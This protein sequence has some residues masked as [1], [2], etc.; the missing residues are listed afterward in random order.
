MEGQEG[1]G[2]GMELQQKGWN[3]CQISK[4]GPRYYFFIQI[5]DMAGNLQTLMQRRRKP[6]LFSSTVQLACNSR[7]H[8]N[9]RDN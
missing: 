9:P 6:E 3:R 4:L 1:K 7:H 8:F 2:Y 5:K